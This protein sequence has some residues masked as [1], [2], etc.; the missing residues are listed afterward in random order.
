M[1]KEKELEI[2]DYDAVRSI[3]LD[4][5]VTDEY[6]LSAKKLEKSKVVKMLVKEYEF[7]DSRVQSA[8]QK[9]EKTEKTRAQTSL[10]NW[11]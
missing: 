2:E 3:F 6:D 8:I 7:S 11:S 10:E 9:V 1:L 4:P 5:K